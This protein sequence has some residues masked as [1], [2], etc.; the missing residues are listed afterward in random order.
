MKAFLLVL[1]SLLALSFVPS[2]SATAIP[3]CTPQVGQWQVCASGSCIVVD[4][5]AL[6]EVVCPG[7]VVADYCTPNWSQWR[8]CVEYPC[9]IV[10]G[11]AL[12]AEKCLP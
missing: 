8:A 6:H 10:D 9:V 4:G 3:A 1:S 12:H 2:A 11:P 5:P 7:V